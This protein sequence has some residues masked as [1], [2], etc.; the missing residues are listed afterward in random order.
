[1]DHFMKKNKQTNS[2]LESL[3]SFRQ[4]MITKMS[5]GNQ[6]IIRRNLPGTKACNFSSWAEEAFD[7]MDST[8]AVQQYI[9]Q[10]IRKDPQGESYQAE[11]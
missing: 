3:S 5:D 2:D 1:M 7:E 11:S 8:L 4:K 6:T 10:I 9:Q